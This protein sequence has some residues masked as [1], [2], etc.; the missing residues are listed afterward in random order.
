VSGRANGSTVPDDPQR[1]I[2]EKDREIAQLRREN[3]RLERDRDRLRRENERLHRELETA[4]RAAKRQAAPFSK[5]APT[6]T[7]KRPGRKAGRAYGRRAT[8][9]QPLRIDE[10]IRV[11][12]PATCPHCAGA[13]RP[14]HTARQLQAD[15]PVV[16]PTVCAFQIVIGRCRQ[17]GR[18]VQ[19]RHPRQTSDALGAA[20]HHLGPHALALTA[21]L[22]TALG[23][24]Y[25]KIARLFTTAFG[26]P[27][28][29]STLCRAL[30]R[31]A[32]RAGP[33]YATLTMQVRRS[34]HVS[35]DETG[36][37]VAACL[38][39]LWAAVTRDTTVYRVQPGRGFDE[40]AALIGGDYAGVLVRDGWAPYRRFAA[41]THQ[42]CVAHLL[43]RCHGLVE[44]LAPTTAQWP[45]DIAAVLTRALA[46]RDRHAAGTVSAPGLAIATGR[47][48]AQWL[49][50]LARPRRHPAL[51][52]LAHHLDA[53][54]TALFTFLVCPDTDATTWRAEQAIRPAVI[55]RKVCGGNR[56][57]RG[58]RTHEVLATLL[59]TAHQRRLDPHPILTDLLHAR[60]P[61]PAPALLTPPLVRSPR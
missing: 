43:R 59:Q 37:K 57:P 5:G 61:M 50:L 6:A 36:W 38:E 24:P 9:P 27:V 58:A 35:V 4:R 60:T 49:R 42:T 40:A 39:W 30:A 18:R 41:A 28:Q 20:A 1:I 12:L 7:P 25:A 31:V 54:L 22:H 21:T 19:G 13:V 32:T 56:S 8:R 26:L 46:L 23:V 2:D 52:R 53:E 16:R 34:G 33:T 47:L 14:T 44:I 51:R 48:L 10:T 11:P 29:R 55:L 15:V 17:C 45:R 3:E